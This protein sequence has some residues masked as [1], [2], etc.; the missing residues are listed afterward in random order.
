M[1]V[2]LESA[3]PTI[4]RNSA[5]VATSNVAAEKE[6]YLKDM[7]LRY[8]PM[9]KI[10][11]AKM[12][13]GLPAHAD[14]QELESV[15]LT[16]LIAAID[17]FDASRGYTFETYAS[18]R[19]R[20]AILDELRAMDMMPRSV[21]TKQR[22]LNKVVES[23][24][25]SLGRTPTDEEVRAELGLDARQYDKLRSQTKPISLIFLD[26]NQTEEDSNPHDT[27]A[28]ESQENFPERLEERELQEL[29]ARKIMELPDVQK[30]VL[31]LYFYE[32]M[33]LAEIGKIMGLSEARVSQIRSQALSHLRKFVGRMTY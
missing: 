28:D 27:I 33:R 10:I 3:Q 20:G 22:R 21:R 14:L 23:L 26:R 11:V 16:G 19:I 12:R 13:E 6:S 31:A 32:E 5:P 18:I 15:G 2:E 24:E 9:V 8:S 30:K 17:R 1:T 7:L 25:Q 4:S 29:V